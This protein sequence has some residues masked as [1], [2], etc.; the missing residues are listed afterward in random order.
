MPGPFFEHVF[1]YAIRTEFQGRGTLHIH[2]ALWAIARAGL[3]LTGRTDEKRS[4]LVAF[5]ENLFDARVDVQAGSGWLN[6]I[7]GYTTK[8]NEALNFALSDHR[9]ANPVWSQTYRL[10]C[11]KAPLLPEVFVGFAQLQQMQ[12]SFYI[13]HLYAVLPSRA[14]VASD[15]AYRSR[16]HDSHDQ[17]V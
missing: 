13:D 8:S 3:D 12:R 11:K 15:G 16:L 7:N 1:H 4:V 10:L 17:A 14:A 9:E 2:I 5:L 6:Y